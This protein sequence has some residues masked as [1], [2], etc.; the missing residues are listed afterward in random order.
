MKMQF[1]LKNVTGTDLFNRFAATIEE[2]GVGHDNE[3]EWYATLSE[4]GRTWSTCWSGFTYTI[5]N[6]DSP[7]S[8]VVEYDGAHRGFLAQNLIPEEL[9][10]ETIHAEVIEGSALERHEVD[11]FEHTNASLLAEAYGLMQSTRKDFRGRNVLEACFRA[12]E[13]AREVSRYMAR[14]GIQGDTSW[15]HAGNGK[16]F[17][18]SNIEDGDPSIFVTCC[19]GGRQVTVEFS[20]DVTPPEGYVHPEEHSLTEAA[21]QAKA[22]LDRLRPV[23]AIA[24]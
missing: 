17:A 6:P 15:A 9:G 14:I 24:A 18:A 19:P 5:M 22:W 11:K 7:E 12:I 1:T 2:D 4:D 23:L 21:D 10:G 8:A 16:A 13:N 20:V 3:G